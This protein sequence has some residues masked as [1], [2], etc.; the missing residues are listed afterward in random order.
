M[1]YHQCTMLCVMDVRCARFAT[2]RVLGYMCFHIHPLT[3]S[4]SVPIYLFICSTHSYT[5]RYDDMSQQQCSSMGDEHRHA[6]SFHVSCTSADSTLR[7]GHVACVLLPY[8]VVTNLQSCVL[9]HD[10]ARK[11]NEGCVF[12]CMLCAGPGSYLAG[13]VQHVRRHRGR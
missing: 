2:F 13:A 8:V 11:Y 9:L 1:K 6:Q 3:G 7:M 5:V 10:E 4:S 12:Y